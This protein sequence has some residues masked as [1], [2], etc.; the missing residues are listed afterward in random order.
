MDR[1]LNGSPSCKPA[2]LCSQ[3]ACALDQDELPSSKSSPDNFLSIFH[4]NYN[5]M[6]HGVLFGK[7]VMAPKIKLSHAGKPAKVACPKCDAA[8]MFYRSEM[9]YIDEC[10]FESYNFTCEACGS[11]LVG[12]ID[13]ADD[14][15]LVTASS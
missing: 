15:L 6:R 8:F 12:I 2:T 11:T 13:P 7:S 3:H 5:A 14:A 10:G 4:L 9:P 1:G